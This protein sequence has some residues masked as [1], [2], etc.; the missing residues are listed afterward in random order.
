MGTLAKSLVLNRIRTYLGQHLRDRS[1]SI[2]RLWGDHCEY[3]IAQ[4]FRRG[5]QIL[6]LYSRIWGERAMKEMLLLFRKRLQKHA[7]G[8]MMGSVGV[9]MFDWNN[10]RISVESMRQ[11][12]NEIDFVKQLQKDTVVCPVC[13][14]RR[15][16]NYRVEGIAYCTCN[17]KCVP[18]MP[19]NEW[20]PYLERKNMIIW[21]R[22]EKPGLYAYKVYAIY[23]D[24]TANDFMHVQTDVDYRKEWD[25]TA[26]TLDVV[27]ADP[28]SSNSHIIYW[29]MLWPKLFANRDY[30]FNRRYYVDHAQ[31]VM[32]IV[33]K[34]TTH[35][36]CPINPNNQRVKEYWSYMVIKPNNQFNKPG[37]QYVLTYYDDPGVRMPPAI[38]SWVAQK[39]MPDFLNQLYHATVKFAQRRKECEEKTVIRSWNTPQ[40]P[41]FEYPPDPHSQYVSNG[42]C[43]RTA[44]GSIQGPNIDN[45]NSDQEAQTSILEQQNDGTNEPTD[46]ND[47]PDEPEPSK[48]SSWWRYFHPYSYLV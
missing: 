30:V 38:T 45:K 7:R 44:T 26:I 36:H 27:E 5:Q 6:S 46:S 4:R 35:P 12:F 23:P 9:F 41:G 28:S 15:V 11:H 48:Q 34:S 24:V 17:K 29:E 47:S 18:E 21:R 32:V 39:Q 31:K 14:R 22:E 19:K 13:N 1:D 2:L 43:N 3:I 42:K 10:E 33:N 16:I 40:D 37:L 25:K 8:L 20:M